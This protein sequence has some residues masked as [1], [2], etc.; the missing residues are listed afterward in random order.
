MHWAANHLDGLFCVSDAVRNACVAAG[1]RTSLNVIYNGLVDEDQQRRQPSVNGF[2]R[3][4]FLGMN[5]PRKGYR[6]VE[7]WIRQTEGQ[8]IEWHLYGDA[9]E[10]Y[11]AEAASLPDVYPGRVF[12][13]GRK[14][15]STIYPQI[16]LL[17]SPAVEFEPFP[18]VL[19]EAAR[20][21]LPVVTTDLGGSVE[22]VAHGE[23]GF[24]FRSDQPES[25]LG[26]IH[27]L[28]QSPELRSS[29]GRAARARFVAEFRVERMVAQYAAGWSMQQAASRPRSL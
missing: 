18:T 7:N 22:I 20:A 9:H 3:V 2:V 8:P 4:G 14:P 6:V 1:Y 19:L 29:M 11:Q 25:G 27:L 23:T 21:G 16:D 17:I 24:L 15:S 5:A 12:L 26:W 10:S 28:A 13:H